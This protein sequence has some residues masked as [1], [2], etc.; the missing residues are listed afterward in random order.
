MARHWNT[1]THQYVDS[2]E[3]EAFLSEIVAICRKHGLS[4]AHEDHHG[5]FEVHEFSEENVAWLT[6][7]HV[8]LTTKAT[9]I[10]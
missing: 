4:L 7:A 5:A 2:A 10:P 8:R 1:I 3:V 9:R 6:A